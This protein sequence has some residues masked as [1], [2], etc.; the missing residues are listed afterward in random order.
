M[1]ARAERVTEARRLHGLGWS[2]SEI[3]EAVGAARKTVNEYLNDPDLAKDRARRENS[4][5]PRRYSK[6]SR[7]CF[8]CAGYV[9]LV[10]GH[11]VCEDCHDPSPLGGGF[12]FFLT[13]APDLAIRVWHEPN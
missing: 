6:P 2:T 9:K 8:I 7:V 1:S 11:R 5:A 13:L 3:G 4:F 10:A 12:F